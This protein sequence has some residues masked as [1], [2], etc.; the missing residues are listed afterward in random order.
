MSDTKVVHKFPPVLKFLKDPIRY[1]VMYGGR[2]GG[3]S[4]A[5]ARL[6]LLQGMASEIR[7]LCAR[8]FQ[9]SIKDSV[10]S[11]LADQVKSL[12]LSDFYDVQARTI[13]GKNGTEFNYVGLKNNPMSLKSFEGID[14]CWIEEGQTVSKTS[15]DILIP[16]IRKE[17]SEIWVTFNPIL[18]SDETYQRFVVNP[19]PDAKVVKINYSDNPWFPKV[20]EAERVYL[21]NK[22]PDAYL[23]VWEGH[24][25]QTLDGAIYAK[26]LREATE[27]NRITRVPY[28]PTKP[29][30]VFADLGWADKTSLWFAQAIGMEYRIIDFYEGQQNPW[31]FYLKIIQDKPYLV[32]TIYLPHDATSKQLAIGRSIDEL[33]RSAGHKTHVLPRIS[34]EQGINAA[35]T[36]FQQCYFDQEKCAD[37]IQA[38][39]HYR[40]EVDPD[41]G[42]F[43]RKPLHDENSHAA[44]A[45]RYLAMGLT[46]RRAKPKKRRAASGGWMG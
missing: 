25:R 15:W 3:K 28:D 19:P 23:N 38:L 17:D 9:N 37:G 30:N 5:V 4:W 33:T 40:Y 7:V 29:V 36:I 13:R 46:E 44:D 26:E 20:L 31:N 11:L 34:V 18:E 43:S 24:C 14:K 35:R 22:D 1:K 10:H 8:E 27:A 2:G 41:T 21:K 12:G 16:T 45:F 42:Q 6:L 32:D 39:R